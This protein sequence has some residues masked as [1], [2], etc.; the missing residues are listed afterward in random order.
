MSYER[1]PRL[2][3]LAGDDGPGAGSLALLGALGVAAWLAT[4][5]GVRRNPGRVARR[6][7]WLTRW[8]G[9]APPRP[10]RDHVVLWIRDGKQ[11]DDWGPMPLASAKAVQTKS[12]RGGLRGRDRFVIKKLVDK[13]G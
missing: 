4:R 1:D 11:I 10:P 6:K 5:D 8:L 13:K 7:G 12:E 2:R 9:G 3:P